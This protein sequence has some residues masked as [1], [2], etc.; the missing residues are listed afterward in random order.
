[1]QLVRL[2]RQREELQRLAIQDPLTGLFNRCHFEDRLE[3]EFE[4]ARRYQRPFSILMIDIDDFKRINDTYGHDTGDDVLRKVGLVL[5]KKTRR[6]D[7]QVRYGGEEFVLI[8]PEAGLRGAIQVGNKLC[9]EIR[10]LVFSTPTSAFSVTISTGVASSSAKPYSHWKEVF[11]DADRALYKAK[12]SGKDCV[13]TAISYQLRT[14][15]HGQQDQEAKREAITDHGPQTTGLQDQE[16]KRKAQSVNSRQIAA[17]SRQQDN[18]LR[19]TDH[20]TTDHSK[21]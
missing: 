10:K 7:T 21:Q 2:I 6:S 8:I 9:R 17:S 14:T 1:M 15:D 19:T 4:R 13:K 11:K 12:A 5:R 20:G 18:R 3:E 16:A